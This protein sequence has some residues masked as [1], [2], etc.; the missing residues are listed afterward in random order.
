M[1]FTWLFAALV[2]HWHTLVSIAAM[3]AGKDVYCEKPL[4][5]TIDRAQT[6]DQ[7]REKQSAFS[8]PAASSG[9]HKNS[10]SRAN[11]FATDASAN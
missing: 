9:Q 2:D 11:W 4:T 7:S 1:T 6:S 10:G 3:H 5:L 8:K